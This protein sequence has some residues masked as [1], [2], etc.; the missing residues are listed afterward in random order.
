MTVSTTGKTKQI[1]G[2]SAVTAGASRTVGAMAAWFSQPRWRLLRLQ[3]AFVGFLAIGIGYTGPFGTY[4]AVPLWPR[5]LYWVIL[6]YVSWLL[7]KLISTFVGRFKQSSERDYVHAAVVSAPFCAVGALVT[8]G[9][10]V[11]MTSWPASEVL[12][13]WPR[14]FTSWMLTTMGVVVPL[15]LLGRALARE[16]KARWGEGLFGFLMQRLPAKLQDGELLALK[17][18]DHYVRVFTTAGDDL[19]LMRFEDALA[20]LEGYPGAQTH[21]SWWVAV[22]AVEH[23]ERQSGGAAELHLRGGLKAPVSRR[24]RAVLAILQER[25]LETA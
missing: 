11:A 12:S 4:N 19:I 5:V 7:W 10:T 14:M 9:L 15:I 24:R 6:V 21:R 18:E 16:N 25:E 8:L 1:R 3:A 2:W 17:A 22:R 13:H 20:A 23:V